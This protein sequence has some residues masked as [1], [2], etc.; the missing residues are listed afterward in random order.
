[1]AL[2]QRIDCIAHPG[3]HITVA[4]RRPVP[5]TRGP[6]RPWPPEAPPVPS[7]TGAYALGRDGSELAARL[8]SPNFVTSVTARL[9]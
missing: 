7:V 6:P 8:A 3:L 9:D 1:V 5:D 4:A 2:D